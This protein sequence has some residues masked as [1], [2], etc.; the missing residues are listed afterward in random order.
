MFIYQNPMTVGDES[1]VVNDCSSYTPPL[2]STASR[3]I[4]LRSKGSLRGSF[5]LVDE[6]RECKIESF[7]EKS[8]ALYLKTLPNLIQL[9]DQPPSVRFIHRDGRTGS[10]TFD[11]L[12][13]F[14]DGRR[15]FIAVKDEDHA[16]RHDIAGFLQHIAPQIPKNV[17]DGVTLYTEKTLSPAMKSN[18]RL[19]QCVRRDPPHPADQAVLDLIQHIQGQVRIGDIVSASGHGNNGFR[20]VARLIARRVLLLLADEIIS[21]GSLVTVDH[22]H[23]AEAA[24]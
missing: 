8:A 22:R 19:I 18:A 13:H 24:R 9:D 11:F 16:L 7:I 3:K 10:H 20:A 2:R 17:A 6:G 15:I 1:H 12:A 5:V 4:S 14:T 21:Y 23:T